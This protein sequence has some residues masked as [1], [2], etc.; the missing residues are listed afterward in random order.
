MIKSE[1]WP[2]KPLVSN[3]ILLEDSVVQL[4]PFLLCHRF[5][6]LK[7]LPMDLFTHLENVL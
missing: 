2:T 1:I 6:C 5:T 3:P 4:N 7:G